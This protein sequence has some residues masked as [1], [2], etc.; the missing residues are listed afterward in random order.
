VLQLTNFEKI[1]DRRDR[2]RPTVR[3]LIGNAAAG[4]EKALMRLSF[5][6]QSNRKAECLALCL[7]R[8]HGPPIGVSNS[9]M[10]VQ[11]HGRPLCA[12][13][14]IVIDCRQ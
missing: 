9:Q 6:A 1:L 7:P 3:P 10:Q 8:R 11:W 14:T 5:E 2:R 4:A 13:A 12:N